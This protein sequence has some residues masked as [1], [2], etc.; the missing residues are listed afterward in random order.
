MVINRLVH[1]FTIATVAGMLAACGGS[2]HNSGGGGGANGNN[3]Q[4]IVVNTGPVAG[5]LYPNGVFTS[6]TVCVPSSSTC[7]TVDGIL[8]D[9][10]S[11]GL[12]ILGSALTV[13][14]PQETSGSNTIFNCASFVDA[15]FLWGPMAQADVKLAG[16]VASKIGVHVVEDPTGFTIPTACSNGG[17]DID[18][19]TLLGANGILGV[20]M[21]AQDCGPACVS[22]GTPPNAYFSC[23]TSGNCQTTFVP[24]AQQ[25]TN[26]VAA[27]P[28]DNNGVQIQ[29][30]AVNGVA[31]TLNGSMV[32]GIGTQSNNGL[33][34]AKVFTVDS[35]D[36]FTTNF[37]QQAMTKSFI[38]SGSNGFFFP[39][40]SIPACL[41]TS[42]APGFFCPTST[43]NLS[44]QTVGTNSTQN[45]VNFS[46]ANANTLFQT[47]P[48]DAAFSQLGGPSFTSGCGG[49]CGFDWGLPFFY[50]RNVFTAI[51]GQT[52]PSGAPAGP[53]W[54]Y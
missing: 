17:K 48:N 39:D 46:V 54:A 20:G 44:A 7:Q 15:T 21:E 28:Q 45:T 42:N 14:L 12:R 51:R 24:L 49:P 19:Q 3:V 35:S 26:P 23:S 27:F 8:V 30:P 41:S 16:E 22:G 2:S 6:V 25:L 18:S 52:M 53:W 9:T 33:G 37:N 4:P 32:F 50:G 29:L 40:S 10:G 11:F 13:S 31:A 47:N 1:L 36:N 38:D 43:M 34:S 5:Q